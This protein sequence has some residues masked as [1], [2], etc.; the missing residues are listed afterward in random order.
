MLSGCYEVTPASLALS[1]SVLVCVWLVLV[2]F[3]IQDVWVLRQ[4]RICYAGALSAGN[5]LKTWGERIK[6]LRPTYAIL[7]Q[8]GVVMHTCN[9]ST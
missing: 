1:M 8:V 7:F 4:G 6:R 3:S 5:L 2:L 9:L